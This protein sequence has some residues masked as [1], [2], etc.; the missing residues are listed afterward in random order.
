MLGLPSPNS[1]RVPFIFVALAVFMLAVRAPSCHAF[2]HSPSFTTSRHLWKQR[3]RN[4]NNF[5]V[6][7]FS[8]RFCSTRASETSLTEA[9]DS[10][11]PNMPSVSSRI[12]GTLDPC[13]VLMKELIGQY[14]H[15]WKNKGG[16]F[17]LAQ[18]VVYWKPP[19]V[20]TTALVTALQKDAQPTDD[21]SSTAPPLL[22]TYGPDEGLP[23]LRSAIQQKIK[24]E[25]GLTNHEVMVTVGANQAYTNCILSLINQNQKVVVFAP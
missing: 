9:K 10:T 15:L 14:A 6:T 16:I 13:V 24:R 1:P 20:V 4:R 17:S 18:G 11:I 22:H 3:P 23:A 19:G 21:S 2:R 25:N 12:Q 5:P 7:S 8:L